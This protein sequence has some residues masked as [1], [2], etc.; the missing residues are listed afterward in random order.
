M[1]SK[2]TNTKRRK[3]VDT[4]GFLYKVAGLIDET[5]KRWATLV[6][7]EPPTREGPAATEK[8]GTDEYD[9]CS[10]PCITDQRSARDDVERDYPATIPE[11]NPTGEDT[12]TKMETVARAIVHSE[13][14]EL[15]LPHQEQSYDSVNR[16]SEDMD[17]P[18][19]QDLDLKESRSNSQDVLSSQGLDPQLS[20]SRSHLSDHEK[21]LYD[22][23]SNNSVAVDLPS[24]HV[25][26]ETVPF[27]TLKTKFESLSMR[28]IPSPADA[29]TNKNSEEAVVGK[30]DGRSLR[31]SKDK[32]VRLFVGKNRQS[33]KQAKK[34][35]RFP[36]FRNKE[37]IGRRGQRKAG[38]L[39]GILKNRSKAEPSMV[40]SPLF[41]NRA[42]QR[43][44]EPKSKSANK[45]LKKLQ[46]KE[47]AATL[48]GTPQ[49]KR[50]DQSETK[51]STIPQKMFAM[52]GKMSFLRMRK[53]DEKKTSAVDETREADPS[54]RD[55][56]FT[57]QRPK[58]RT[59]D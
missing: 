48:F 41:F 58:V 33:R 16:N 57:N 54:N 14:F 32:T 17:D 36:G 26:E 34:N 11:P 49:R 18:I 53:G 56:D 9:A 19:S 31:K 55:V 52:K 51:A 39:E 47:R 29:S 42:I 10:N 3:D 24:Y 38:Q 2:R 4:S 43:E 7:G 5:G 1:V 40:R 50:N 44:R 13:G 27:E 35:V 12:S 20:R 28:N 22:L 23:L 21:N 8:R 45:E 59:N 37:L 15:E 46:K 6:D 25:E 30:K